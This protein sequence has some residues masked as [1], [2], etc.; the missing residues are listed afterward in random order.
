MFCST[1]PALYMG[2]VW[3]WFFARETLLWIAHTVVYT[4]VRRNKEEET[5]NSPQFLP[6]ILSTESLFC[7]C[8]VVLGSFSTLRFYSLWFVLELRMGN[9]SYVKNKER[10]KIKGP[11]DFN[12]EKIEHK[13]FIDH[14][15]AMKCHN[16]CKIK[17]ALRVQTQCTIVLLN[18]NTILS[19]KISSNCLSTK[20]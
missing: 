16:N 3:E 7:V 13:N 10:I 1:P 17:T 8:I 9:G 5:K 6:L 19:V 20:G 18:L 4:S 14:C 15:C 2:V 11:H 12:V